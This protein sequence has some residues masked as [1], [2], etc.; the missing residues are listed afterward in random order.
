MGCVDLRLRRF[1]RFSTV[2]FDRFST[3]LYFH[4]NLVPNKSWYRYIANTAVTVGDS[5]VAVSDCLVVCD[6]LSTVGGR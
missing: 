5:V 6:P 4:T 1:D 2:T 3:I